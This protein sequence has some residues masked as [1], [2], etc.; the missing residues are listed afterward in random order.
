M[1]DVVASSIRASKAR[2]ML[3]NW[4]TDF[5]TVSESWYL[6][7]SAGAAFFGEAPALP[8]GN[9]LHAW[10]WP[11][12]PSPSPIRSHRRNGWSGASTCASRAPSGRYGARVKRSIP[13]NKHK[14]RE[15]YGLSF[16]YSRFSRRLRKATVTP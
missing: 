14:K 5:L 13:L 6:G 12:M 7:T 4:Q 8:R 9:P 11:T 15:P 1:F 2:R 16:S 3:D 10:W